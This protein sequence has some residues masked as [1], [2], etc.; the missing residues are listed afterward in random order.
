MG[1]R[2]DRERWRTA[3]ERLLA[4]DMGV[5]RHAHGIVKRNGIQSVNRRTLLL[6][7]LHLL[8]GQRVAV[9]AF[10]GLLVLSIIGL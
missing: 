5:D 2:W 1:D 4:T 3:A 8:I 10:S 7:A 6:K 9:R